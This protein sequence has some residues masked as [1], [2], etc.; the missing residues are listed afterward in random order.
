MTARL[1][2]TRD[3]CVVQFILSYVFIMGGYIVK[4]AED[5]RRKPI[6]RVVIIWAVERSFR[7]SC[8]WSRNPVGGHRFEGWRRCRRHGCLIRR[9]AQD[10]G[11]IERSRIPD[12]DVWFCDDLEVFDDP[13]EFVVHLEDGIWSATLVLHLDDG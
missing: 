13:D 4:Y 6:S 8:R 9:L 12:P 11:R 2:A 3:C 1:G 5:N 7:W 10:I